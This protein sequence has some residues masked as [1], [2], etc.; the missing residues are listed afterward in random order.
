LA[1]EPSELTFTNSIRFEEVAFRHP[2]SAFGLNDISF[3]LP[4]GARLGIVGATGSGKSTLA[5]LLM[6]LLE[7]TSGAIYI[8]GVALTGENRSA[9]RKRV[10]HVPQSIFL[11]DQSIAENIAFSAAPGTPLD[12]QR[13]RECAAAAGIGSFIEALP[14]GY[15]TK[16][17]ERGVR[18]SGGQR[19]RLGI[20]RALYK[21]ASV[22]V[23][24]EATNAL[25]GDTEAAVLTS[26]ATLK[27]VTLIVV[28]HRAASLALCTQF[29]CLEDGRIGGAASNPTTTAAGELP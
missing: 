29:V 13:V 1:R 6:G 20:A 24:D 5:D 22:L 12:L 23:L 11:T 21:G 3:T 26:L 19:Q 18:L 9:W 17:G 27:D 10:G 28:A 14:E 16:G 4:A 7:P 8:D 15:F 2:G 25:D